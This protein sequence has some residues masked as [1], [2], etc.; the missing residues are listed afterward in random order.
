M[1]AFKITNAATA[2]LQVFSNVGTKLYGKKTKGGAATGTDGSAAAAAAAMGNTDSSATE[3]NSDCVSVE[4]TTTDN[5]QAEDHNPN[6]LLSP[7]RQLG[8]ASEHG[9][10]PV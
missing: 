7:S 4:S 5:S 10:L 6:Q 8:N 3:L 2:L 9:G 1:Y